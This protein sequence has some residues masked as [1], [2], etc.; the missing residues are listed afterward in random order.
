MKTMFFRHLIPS[1]LAIIGLASNAQAQV[2][3]NELDAQTPG[4]DMAEFVEL[5]DGGVGN[6]SLD[7]LILVLFNGSGDNNLSYLAADLTGFTTDSNGFF[8]IGSPGMPGVGLDLGTGWLQ[9]G[10]DGAA[11]YADTVAT[12][13]NG[14]VATTTNL[15]DAVVYGTNDS[16]PTLVT[17]LGL[18]GATLNEDLNGNQNT[19]SVGRTIDG[20]GGTNLDTDWT[21]YESPTPGGPNNPEEEISAGLSV[22]S[23]SENGG[24][25]TLT[26][27]IDSPADGDITL[28]I[29]VRT[30]D[31]T[32][33]IIPNAIIADGTSS[34][35]VTL[36]GRDDAWRDFDQ[37]LTLDISDPL[38]RFFPAEVVI[39]ITDDE[40]GSPVGTGLRVNEVYP[41]IDADANGD[42]EVVFDGSDEFVELV[43]DSDS[44]LDISGYTLSDFATVRHT[45]PAGTVLDPGCAIVVF[46]KH[47]PE[48]RP[49]GFGG[50]LVQNANGANEFGLSLT[51][52]AD[53]ISVENTSG[54]EVAG[55]NWVDAFGPN[56]SLTLDPDLNATNAYTVHFNFGTPFSPGLTTTGDPFCIALALTASVSPNSISEDAGPGAVTLTVTRD[57]PL[58]A[59]M[60]VNLAGS[61][62]TEAIVPT[63]ATFDIGEDEVN[64]PLDI[65]NDS[66]ADGTQTVTITAMA[67][68]FVDASTTL[69]VVDD[70]DAA[71]T[72]FINEV[73][74][75]QTGSDDM[76]FVEIY[77]GGTGN[78]PLDGFVIVSY[79]GNGGTEVATMDLNGAQ[80]NA[81]GFYAAFFPANSFQNGPDEAVALWS[82]V[83][84]GDFNGTT[85][86]TPPAGAVL[87]DAIT[88]ESGESTIHTTLGYDGPDLA[89]SNAEDSPSLSRS[90]DGTGDFALLSPTPNAPNGIVTASAY[91]TW[92]A[93]FPGI[94]E[95]E[96][97]DEFD[98]IPNVLEFALGFDPTE[99]NSLPD[100]EINGG[101]GNL[102]FTVGKG[103]EAGS[104]PDT[105]YFAEVSTDGENWSDVDLAIITDDANTFAAEYT[106]N[107][108]V[109]LL[110]IGVNVAP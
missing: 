76:E 65:V 80:T 3:I 34:V 66:A 26:I 2:K 90:P 94:G 108:P 74:Y 99:N 84:A 37:T 32:E 92:A 6:T 38:N 51:N 105:S 81:Q 82:G 58:D 52:A 9:N 30:F 8:L 16:V 87:I 72:L 46:G 15:V 4:A 47:A 73:D 27:G 36:T 53:L 109:A 93:G 10:G 5:S 85:S 45:F 77:D 86:D 20:A 70:G 11:I 69:D 7:G 14:T 13:P 60:Q 41:A 29:F 106:G 21:T 101:T 28:D 23:I 78:T 33:L 63:S 61:D 44:S 18:T 50:A 68:G 49:E 91:D 107:S 59:I 62:P 110:R 22:A 100:P 17:A 54:V 104:D 56:G 39:T 19:A 35:D 71:P 67:P 103:A 1:L 79:N 89:D 57:G 96:D 42:G 64:V 12:F 75:D 98:G 97:D 95:R 31:N 88:Y 25:S 40:T 48:G 43:N 55:A 83:A 24:T 102:R